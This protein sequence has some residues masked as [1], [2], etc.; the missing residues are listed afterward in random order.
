[1]SNTGLSHRSFIGFLILSA[2]MIVALTAPVWAQSPPLIDRELFF[3]DPEIAGAQISP[4]GAYIAFVKPF[5][6][7]RNVWVK[8]TADP[9][10]SAKP[11]TADTKR[12]IPTFF[13]SRDGKY[14]L[15]VQDKAG[16]ENY[17][18]YAVNPATR[19]RRDKMCQPLEIS[20]KQKGFAQLFILSRG[21]IP[22]PSTLVSMIETQP[23]TISTK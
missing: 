18:V 21:A 6:G 17:N 23:G 20:P 10:T 14:I 11:I 4:D 13:W 1:M 12:P 5:N 15:F 16:D 22:M 8:R 7:T 2:L 19:P 9:F 3:G